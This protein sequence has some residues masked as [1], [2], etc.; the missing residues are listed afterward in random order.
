MPDLPGAARVGGVA[1]VALGGVAGAGAGTAGAAFLL[2]PLVAA[3]ARFSP[4]K[5]ETGP[6]AKARV[7]L[8]ARCIFSAKAQVALGSEAKSHSSLFY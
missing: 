7:T 4:R 3:Q 8:S 5:S 1:G 2:G 6:A